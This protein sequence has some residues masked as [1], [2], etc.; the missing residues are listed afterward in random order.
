ML[1]HDAARFVPSGVGV[2]E[3]GQFLIYL[4][5]L[6]A[7]TQIGGTLA[8]AGLRSVK[9]RRQ[10]ALTLEEFRGRVLRAAKSGDNEDAG[11]RGAWQS[12]RKFVIDR[13]VEEAADIRSYYLRPYDG[14]PIPAFEPGQHLTFQLNVA[15]QPKPVIRCY[16]LSEAP[17]ASGQYR[18]TIRRQSAPADQADVPD[19]LASSFFHDVLQEGDTIDARAPS[20]R[21]CLD[22][23]DTRPAVLV[24]GGIGVTPL[25][26]MLN[27]IVSEQP[28]RKVW[29]FYGLHDRK[30]F[31]FEEHL[32]EIERTHRNVNTHIRFG[33]AAKSDTD[34]QGRITANLI[35]QELPNKNCAFYVCGPA[36][37]MQD[38][39]QGLRDWGVLEGDIHFEPFGASTA[40][41]GTERRTADI[42]AESGSTSLAI[43]FKRSR[44]SA[45]WTGASEVLLDLAEANGIKL[46][47]GCRAGQCGSC[48]V[49]LIEGSVDYV[50]EPG[51]AV[52]EGH[53]LACVAVPMTELV[54]D[55]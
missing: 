54:I 32:A 19:G 18:I 2:G 3:L 50:V 43:T 30:H 48:A 22:I 38:I 7:L 47:S 17:N 53:C 12:V 8:R 36:A 40:K 5:G 49:P 13:I 51:L 52:A 14:K 11:L 24:A 33:R 34:R 41:S 9:N 4:V 23:Q 26:S 1:A 45:R 42:T 28:R 31:A 25:I 55:A 15:D 35:E 20:G 39:T 46:P 21:F 44:K 37:M 16:S 10:A 29:V 27:A 6:A